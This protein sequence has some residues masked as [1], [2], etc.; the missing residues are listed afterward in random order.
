MAEAWHLDSWLDQSETGSH[1]VS[2][3]YS[4]ADRERLVMPCHAHA[5]ARRCS[6]NSAALGPSDLDDNPEG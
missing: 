5:H 6:R 1:D 2:E 3:E 4:G